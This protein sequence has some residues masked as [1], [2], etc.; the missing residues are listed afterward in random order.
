MKIWE[1]KRNIDNIPHIHARN[2]YAKNLYLNLDPE[3]IL[4]RYT[5]QSIQS[6]DSLWKIIEKYCKIKKVRGWC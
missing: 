3:D 2:E 4:F 1:E 6:A 5:Y